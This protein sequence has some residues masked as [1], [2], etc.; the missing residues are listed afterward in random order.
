MMRFLR[1]PAVAEAFKAA[2]RLRPAFRLAPKKQKCL[3]L[4][5][6]KGNAG[7]L[8]QVERPQLDALIEEVLD[9]REELAKAVSE[10]LANRKRLKSRNGA[11]RQ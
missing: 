5:L 9:K 7:E 6:Q 4:L 10:S 3:S 2:R 8:T 1:P 11:A